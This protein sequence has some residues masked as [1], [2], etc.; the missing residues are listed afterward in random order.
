MSVRG[1][2]KKPDL[3]IK[4]RDRL[5]VVD[6]TVR[7]ENTATL[8]RAFADKSE[9]YAETASYIKQRTRSTKA[10]VLPIV[11]GSRGAM[12]LRTVNNLKTLGLSKSDMLTISMIALR[13]SIEIANAFI[14][15]DRIQ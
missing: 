12:P 4:D 6:V 11:V 9:K 1:E 14:D 10:E 15:Y 5:F 8:Q 3:V 7:Y 13:S 2:L